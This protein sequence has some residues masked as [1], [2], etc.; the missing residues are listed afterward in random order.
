MG[1]IEI[2]VRLDSDRCKSCINCT[3]LINELDRL[4]YVVGCDRVPFGILPVYKWIDYTFCRK[5]F[6]E[7]RKKKRTIKLPPECMTACP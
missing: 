4:E 2:R 5:C 6:V 7:I 1:L 3:G